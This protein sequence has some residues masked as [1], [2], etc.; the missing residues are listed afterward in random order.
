MGNRGSKSKHHTGNGVITE[1]GYYRVYSVEQGRQIFEHVRI[2][3]QVYG[4]IPKGFQIHHKDANKQNNS[5]DN[6]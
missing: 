4:P 3:E 6:L 1:K 2:W 5:I